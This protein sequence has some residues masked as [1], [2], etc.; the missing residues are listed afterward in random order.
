MSFDEAVVD[1][2]ATRNA[3]EQR[4]VDA[5]SRLGQ[6]AVTPQNNQR[7]DIR[8]P[9]FRQI[10]VSNAAG[11]ALGGLAFSRDITPQGLGFV[12]SEYIEDNFLIIDVETESGTLRFLAERIWTNPVGPGWY[13]SG[14]V[15]TAI[16]DHET[17][18]T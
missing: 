13:S 8:I 2:L 4:F 16:S 9:Y 11:Q 6:E 15:F 14:A 7:G 3:V 5:M 17:E 1:E 12:H 18:T 10:R